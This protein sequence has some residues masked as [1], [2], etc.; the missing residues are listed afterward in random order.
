MT[1]RV[2][3]RHKPDRADLQLYYIHP[4]TRREVTKSAGTSD[5]GQA[6]RAASRWEEE[7]SAHFGVGGDG[8]QHF[9]DRLRNEYLAMLAHKT[10]LSYNTALN[11]FGRLMEP[12]SVATIDSTAISVFQSKLLQEHRPLSSIANYLTHIRSVLNWAEQMGITRKAPLIKMPRQPRRTFMRGRPITEA[13]YRAMLRACPGPEWQR[14]LEMLWLSGMR[15]SE[16]II[17]SWDAPPVMVNLDAKPYPQLL[18]YAEGQK[19]RRDDAT[20]LAP[21][22]AAWLQQT[23]RKQRRGRVAPLP[24]QTSAR[25]SEEISAIGSAAGIIVNGDDKPASAQDLRRSFGTRWAPH[26]MPLTLQKMM[27]HADISTTMKYYVN[28]NAA[29]VGRELWSV[30]NHVPKKRSGRQPPA[31]ARYKNT[32][33]SSASRSRKST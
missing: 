8:W 27:R 9:R 10:Q 24:F 13:E 16:G 7:L 21:D 26:V 14:F 2:L 18:F 28:L 17:V 22:F 31:N 4:L 1:V 6:E 11:H 23:P 32:N 33:K 30:P 29:D 12:R 3:I 25:I 20:P 5:K 15:L 19:A